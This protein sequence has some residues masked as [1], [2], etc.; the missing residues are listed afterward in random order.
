[1]IEEQEVRRRGRRR[2]PPEIQKIV[3]EFKSGDQTQIEFC[4][5]QGLTLSTLGRY[6]SPVRTSGEASNRGL[7]AGG[8]G[9]KKDG[10]EASGGCGLSVS[11]ASGRRIVVEAGFDA[12]TCSAWCKCWR[13]CRVFGDWAGDPHLP[14]AGGHRHAERI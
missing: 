10:A 1:M 9:A 5:R 13:G 3:S 4:R 6:L 2:T 12:A 7:V 8:V 14:G 11:V